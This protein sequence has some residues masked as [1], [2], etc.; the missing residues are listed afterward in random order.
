M[1]I[2]PTILCQGVCKAHRGVVHRCEVRDIRHGKDWGMFDYCD[3]AI[4]EDRRRGLDVSILDYVPAAQIEK[5]M[6][7]QT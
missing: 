3:E 4:E 6:E 2:R 1:P 7:A 5:T